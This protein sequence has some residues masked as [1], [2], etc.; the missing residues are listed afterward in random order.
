MKSGILIKN[1]IV[2]ALSLLGNRLAAQDS[3]RF[4]GADTVDVEFFSEDDTVP[5][6]MNVFGQI[7]DA[8]S[9]T[10]CGIFCSS[11]TIKLLL[12]N[13]NVSYPDSTIYIVVNCL[14]Y[15]DELIGSFVELKVFALFEDNDKCYHPIINKFHSNSLPFYWIDS[16]ER[17][18]LTFIINNE[19]RE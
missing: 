3:I 9:S 11:G 14:S 12:T 17:A 6:E 10:S 18:K 1:C 15:G 16:N 2:C 19:K 4:F 5:L 13:S 7:I 8:S